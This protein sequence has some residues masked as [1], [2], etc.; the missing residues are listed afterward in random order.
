MIK[1]IWRDCDRRTCAWS[2]RK[3][4]HSVVLSFCFLSTAT[5][6][7]RHST[8]CSTTSACA[9]HSGS[10]TVGYMQ[11][12]YYGDEQKPVRGKDR[13]CQHNGETLP[14]EVHCAEEVICKQCSVKRGNSNVVNFSGSRKLSAAV[15]VLQVRMKMLN[16]VQSIAN[17]FHHFTRYI[18]FLDDLDGSFRHHFSFLFRLNVS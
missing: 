10:R 11:H 3:R 7:A 9:L 8:F 4:T 14:D 6:V 15:A 1:N 5:A 18:W 17:L 13:Q 12:R 2:S 16:G